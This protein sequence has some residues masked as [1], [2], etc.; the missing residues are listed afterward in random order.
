MS[1]TARE[2]AE[3]T[4]A[5]VRLG[6]QLRRVR[7]QQGLSL[8]DVEAGSG[9]EIK[10]SV[11]GAYERGERSLSLARLH[12]LAEFFRVPV[13]E[14]LPGTRTAAGEPGASERI[15]IDLVALEG[16]RDHLPVLARYVERLKS[17]RGDHGGRILTVRTED[18]RTLAAAQ[19]TSTQALRE[20]LAT[21]RTGR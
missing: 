19:G 2:S 1:G 16:R 7:A 21:V 6:R 3:P 14:L 18:L 11:L 13:S 9:G 12:L 4:E 10:A 20:K 17:L 15:V 5:D 8:H